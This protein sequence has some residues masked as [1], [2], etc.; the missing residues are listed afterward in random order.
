[1]RDDC[2]KDGLFDIT[3][4]EPLARLGYKDYTRVTEV[5]SLTRPVES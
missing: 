3:T 4:F 2:L 5:F 1:M